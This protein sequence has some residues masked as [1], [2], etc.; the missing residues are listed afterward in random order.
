MKVRELSLIGTKGYAELNYL[1]QTL[2]IYKS[3]YEKKFD[4]YGD[5]IVKFGTPH[6]EEL[7]LAGREPL[8]SEIENFINF[9]S[10]KNGHV[11]SA[12]EGL[13]ALRIALKATRAAQRANHHA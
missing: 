12:R 1:N 10:K 9:L 8:Q 5:Y 7:N 13:H 2:K 11:V 3:N 4:S 6:A